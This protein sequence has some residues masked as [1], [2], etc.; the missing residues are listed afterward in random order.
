[1]QHG[2]GIT[3]RYQR[4]EERQEILIEEGKEP[5]IL[6]SWRMTSSRVERT[7]AKEILDPEYAVPVEEQD[8]QE[9]LETVNS[10]KCTMTPTTQYLVK[11]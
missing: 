4:T 11:L 1:M 5:T 6:S 8:V 7:V 2:K 10:G 3:C 9:F